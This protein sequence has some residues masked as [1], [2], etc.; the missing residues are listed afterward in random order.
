[1]VIRN[2][3]STI[4]IQ[5]SFTPHRTKHSMRLH[6]R[7]TLYHCIYSGNKKP[8]TLKIET[9]IEGWGD[10]NKA[11]NARSEEAGQLNAI[12]IL[13]CYALS[14]SSFFN[15]QWS[16]KK[17]A[18]KFESVESSISEN[19]KSSVFN[20]GCSSCSPYSLEPKHAPHFS[21]INEIERSVTHFAAISPINENCSFKVY[22][23]EFADT[24]PQTF[25]KAPSFGKHV[26]NRGMVRAQS[27]R[28]RHRQT[29]EAKGSSPKS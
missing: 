28:K 1:M 21:T 22:R 2:A 14:F 18:S 11:I 27:R 16:C 26:H 10:S 19:L 29:H 12:T 25:S 7:N 8:S 17:S 9:N 13:A 5:D 4:S 24:D 23:A 3:R 15:N 20:P 6:V